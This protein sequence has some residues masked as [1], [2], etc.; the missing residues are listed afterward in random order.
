MKTSAHHEGGKLNMNLYDDI[1]EPVPNTCCLLSGLEPRELN[2]K[3]V[4][5]LSFAS[6]SLAALSSAKSA[7]NVPKPLLKPPATQKLMHNVSKR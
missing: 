3:E 1:N 2:K 5:D 6:S 4:V 7:L